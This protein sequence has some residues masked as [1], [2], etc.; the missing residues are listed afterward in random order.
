MVIIMQQAMVSDYLYKPRMQTARK[1]HQLYA[2]EQASVPTAENIILHH[3]RVGKTMNEHLK[4][5][6]DKDSADA[7]LMELCMLI[8]VDLEDVEPL[9][10]EIGDRYV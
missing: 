9:D 7:D 8:D 2:S 4:D 10:F 6:I 5:L 1:L 3:I